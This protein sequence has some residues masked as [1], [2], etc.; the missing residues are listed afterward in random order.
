MAGGGL[1]TRVL[2]PQL[3]SVQ[4]AL[5]HA[6]GA[7]LASPWHSWDTGCSEP[8]P[9]GGRAPIPTLPACPGL[10][11]KRDP[12]PAEPPRLREGRRPALEEPPGLR[13][14]GDA[15]K[16]HKDE[17][18]KGTLRLGRD[19][20]GKWQWRREGAL[21]GAAPEEGSGNE[22]GPRPRDPL[23]ARRSSVRFVSPLG[24]AEGRGSLS[25]GSRRLRR[26]RPCPWGGAPCP[27]GLGQA[28]P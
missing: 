28:L 17:A 16:E 27:R 15:L 23:G 14:A 21:S 4:R 26:P 2:H 20:G 1:P 25:N 8:S 24:A 11:E 18:Q 3:V 10:T 12:L 9:G 19:R 6:P 5:R 22:A 7:F 13:E